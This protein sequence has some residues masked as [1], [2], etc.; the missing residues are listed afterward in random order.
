MGVPY[1]IIKGKL[2][3]RKT[4]T[5]AAFTQVTLED[6]DALDEPVGVIRTNYNG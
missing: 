4:C 5:T 3:H 6:K 2:V 1:C